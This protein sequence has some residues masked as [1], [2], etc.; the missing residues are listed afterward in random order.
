L[1]RNQ[2]NV[3]EWSDMSTCG[4]S[5]LALLK[6]NSACYSSTKQTSLSSYQNVTCSRHDITEKLFISC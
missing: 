6:S 2:N 4:F 3:S 5:E 1:A